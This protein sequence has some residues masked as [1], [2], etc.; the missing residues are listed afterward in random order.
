MARSANPD[1]AN[2]QFFIVFKPA[3]HLDG[4]HCLGKSCGGMNMSKYQ[5]G[6]AIAMVRLITQI[7][8]S[9]A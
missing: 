7:K 5:K 2:S 6:R 9:K 3:P 4:G 1:S 8:L